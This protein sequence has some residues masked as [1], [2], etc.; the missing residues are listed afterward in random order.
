MADHEE[1]S[2]LTV[3]VAITANLG[4]AVAKGIAGAVSGS[5]AMLSEAAHSVADTTNQ[6]LL[7]VAVKRSSRPADSRHQFGYGRERYF[8]TLLAAV[9]IFV[10]GGVFAVLQGIRELTGGHGEGGHYALSFAV[11]G[12]A[13]VLES[14]SW[15]QAVRQLRGDARRTDRS[16]RDQLWHTSDPAA[17][18][19][20]F[21]DTAALAGLVIAGAGVG[22]HQATGQ[23][24]WDPLASIAI[25]LLLTVVAFLLGK[26]NRSLIVGEAA[27]PRLQEALTELLSSYPQVTSV[28]ELLTMVTGRQEV[29][30][31]ARLDL[32]DDLRAAEV[33]ALARRME[34]DIAAAHPTVRHFFVDVTADGKQNEA[35]MRGGPAAV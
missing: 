9:G 26:E 4:I 33:E 27:D 6:A 8:W 19:V 32:E 16:F 14:I 28:Q 29:L 18:T 2:T 7:L 5:A 10:G 3:L 31:A 24:F 25:G 34:R 22:L 23:H 30:V 15:S 21:E 13:F 20:F 35:D 1:E 12:I 17:T 11:L